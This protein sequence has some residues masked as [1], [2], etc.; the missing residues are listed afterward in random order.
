MHNK[1]PQKILKREAKVG[2]IGLG[3]V[4]LP[5][6]LTIAEAGFRVFGVDVDRKKVEMIMAGKSYIED[7]PDEMVRKFVPRY[8]TAHTE[9][10]VLKECEIINIC[11]PTPFNPNKE[12][13]ISY[14]IDSG[15]EIS[16]IM[17]SGQLII[18]RSTTYPETTEKVLLPILNKSGLVLGKDF[19]L[20]FAPERVDPGNKTWTMK[21]TPVVVGG[22]TETCTKLTELFFS[23]F[24]EK[25]YPVSSPKVAEM[26]K[27]LEN[28]FRSVN[29]ALV[30]EMALLCERMGID[31]WEVISAASTKPF[32][33]MPF[34]PGPG[35]GGHCIL[36]DPY[37]LAWKAREY[38]FH[39]NFIELAAETNEEMPYIVC[40]HLFEILGKEGIPASQAKILILGV[41]FKRDVGD[42]RNSPAL[43]VMEILWDKVKSII[44]N[45]PYVSEIKIK[46]KVIKSTKLTPSLLKR[47]DCLLILTDH[48][49]YDYNFILKYAP[50]ILDTRNAIKKRGVKKLYTLGAR[51]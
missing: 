25:V 5:F 17:H 30:N 51:I 39:T 43:K 1:L 50:L 7:V 9:Y 26:S 29:I 2:V 35:I 3:Y 48:S 45:D 22:I 21:N 19:F 10:S 15:K 36:V 32:G 6:S 40:D 27:L 14:I 13:D 41:A 11:V 44:Y 31:I 33:F 12:P 18:L 4:G 23:Q 38:D 20:S 37:Y 46:D 16:K 24:T 28:I 49:S 8:F 34:Y 42:I 47:I